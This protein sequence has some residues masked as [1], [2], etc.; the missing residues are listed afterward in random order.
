MKAGQKWFHYGA[1]LSAVGI[2]FFGQV[3]FTLA[4]GAASCGDISWD[5][6]DLVFLMPLYYLAAPIAAILLIAVPYVT[7][8]HVP[9]SS[10]ACRPL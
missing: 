1:A 6:Y 8:Y 9:R 2:I 5:A 7:A 3:L 4:Y 10:V